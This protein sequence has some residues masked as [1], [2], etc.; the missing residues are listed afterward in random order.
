LPT[1]YKKF[2]AYEGDVPFMD[3]DLNFD[4]LLPGFDAAEVSR[5]VEAKLDAFVAALPSR[6]FSLTPE[7]VKRFASFVD[8]QLRRGR[9]IGQ[10]ELETMWRWCFQF[11]IFAEDELGYNRPAGE[12][13]PAAAPTLDELLKSGV[14]VDDPEVK[15]AVASATI[16]G[17]WADIWA[18]WVQSLR[19]Q[20]GFEMTQTANERAYAWFKTQNES[21]Q[22]LHGEYDRCRL[23]LR[24]NFLIPSHAITNRERATELFDRG[25]I[26]ARAFKREIEFHTVNKSL[27][28]PI[29]RA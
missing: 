20:F 8:A 13:A 29:P 18:Q 21:L 6:G 3:V 7:G 4:E 14:S 15:H 24:R 5:I 28:L 11:Q 9:K 16:E 25:E 27:D 2:V 1:I 17:I 12:P 19:T 22:G 10:D 23:H 26:D